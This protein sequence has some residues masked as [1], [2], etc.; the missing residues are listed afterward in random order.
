MFTYGA[1]NPNDTDWGEDLLLACEPL[2]VFRKRERMLHRNQRNRLSATYDILGKLY[3]RLISDKVN[4]Y[5]GNYE[6]LV[7]GIDSRRKKISCSENPGLY[8]LVRSAIIITIC[9]SDDSIQSHTKEMHWG[10]QFF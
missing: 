3:N 5:R 1:E 9:N 8:I 10:L 2:T 4:V 6:K 7:S